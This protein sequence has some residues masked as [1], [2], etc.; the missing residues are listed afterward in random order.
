MKTRGEPAE[1]AVRCV[2]LTHEMGLFDP[3]SLRTAAVS[4]LS[5]IIFLPQTPGK[6]DKTTTA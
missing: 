2:I 5:L 3:I 6:N 1:F 4:I